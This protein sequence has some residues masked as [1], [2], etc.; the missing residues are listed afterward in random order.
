MPGGGPMCRNWI[1][2]SKGM[3][4]FDFQRFHRPT[5]PSAGADTFLTSSVRIIESLSAAPIST[6]D[7]MPP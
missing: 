5:I 6:P 3:T 7:S 4:N 1:P 2:A